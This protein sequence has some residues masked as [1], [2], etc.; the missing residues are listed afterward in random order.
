M[1]RIEWIAYAVGMFARHPK[2]S[3]VHIFKAA[4]RIANRIGCTGEEGDNLID[5]SQGDQRGLTLARFRKQF[6]HRSG[7]NPKGPLG[8]HEQVFELISGVVFSKP[9]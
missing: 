8:T 9:F 3:P 6:Q 7:D 4:E 5:I 1:R 2:A